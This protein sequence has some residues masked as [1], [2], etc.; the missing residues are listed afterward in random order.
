MSAAVDLPDNPP[1]WVFDADSAT[2][3]AP[4][5]WRPLLMPEDPLWSRLLDGND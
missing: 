2:K 3:A 5:G 1:D 4:K